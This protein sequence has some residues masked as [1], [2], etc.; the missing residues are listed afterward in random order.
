[1]NPFSSFIETLRQQPHLFGAY[2]ITFIMILGYV[3]SLVR[4]RQQVM[5]EADAV[6]RA[7]DK[8]P[9]AQ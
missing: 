9:A 7:V 1:M 3:V 6:T 5:R 4:R 2:A 8:G